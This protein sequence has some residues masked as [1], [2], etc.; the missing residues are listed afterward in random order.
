MPHW[1]RDV[2]E[3]IRVGDPGGWGIEADYD[4]VAGSGT[5]SPRVRPTVT[6]TSGA[7]ATGLCR[8]HRRSS[9]RR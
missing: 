7:E 9:E 4:V 1:C 8:R 6:A 3:P 5:T 2:I